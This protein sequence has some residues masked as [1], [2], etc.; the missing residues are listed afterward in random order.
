VVCDALNRREV[1]ARE[2]RRTV[3]DAVRG[4]TEDA[5]AVAPVGN[6]R[7]L[8]SESGPIDFEYLLRDAFG[9]QRLTTTF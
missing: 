3:P 6:S 5:V 2:S 8:L 1:A 9:V 4:D 7:G